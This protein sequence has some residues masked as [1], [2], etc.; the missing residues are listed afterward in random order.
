MLNNRLAIGLLMLHAFIA[1]L[2]GVAA[3]EVKIIDLGTNPKTDRHEIRIDLQLSDEFVPLDMVLMP[4]GEFLLEIGRDYKRPVT[5]SRP[6][7]IGKY[8]LS[9]KQWLVAGKLPN[10][11]AHQ[12]DNSP[13][14]QI[15]WFQCQQFIEKLNSLGLGHFRFPTEAELEY[16]CKAGDDQAECEGRDEVQRLFPSEVN[17]H[18]PNEWGIYDSC[19]GVFEWCQDWVDFS[20]SE[21]PVIDPVGPDT[22]VFKMA[23]GCSFMNFSPMQCCSLYTSVQPQYV[24]EDIGFR[25]VMDVEDAITSNWDELN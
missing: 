13:I 10:R 8:E 6:F 24:R 19:N 17:Q 25:L 14:E 18:A 21:S 4:P 5:L 7:Y 3:S 22:G 12:N 15:S 9:Q 16:A 20:V 23:K 2:M 1:S 11:S